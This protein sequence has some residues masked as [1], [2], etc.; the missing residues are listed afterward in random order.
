[1]Q[2]W[3]HGGLKLAS[4]PFGI[5][6]AFMSSSPLS[7]SEVRVAVVPLILLN[8]R[9]NLRQYRYASVLRKLGDFN[10]RP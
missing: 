2:G 7:D 10:G 8:A 6:A 4:Q 5:I 3:I 1:M 9:Q